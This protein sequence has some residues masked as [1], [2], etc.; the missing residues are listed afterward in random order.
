[1]RIGKGIN[2]AVFTAPIIR[3]WP[4]FVCFFVM[5]GFTTLKSMIANIVNPQYFAGLITWQLPLA[6]CVTYLATCIVHFFRKTWVKVVMYAIGVALFMLYMFLWR[7]FGLYIQP[8][9]VTLLVETN[10]REAS[11][12]LHTF[13][14]S[15]GG[16]TAI[17]ASVVMVALIVG[18]E[19]CREAVSARFVHVKWRNY[20]L[21][22]LL[23]LIA[24]GAYQ[25]KTYGRLATMRTVE[26]APLTGD[27][28]SFDAVTSVA[29]SVLSIPVAQREYDEALL[30][31]TNIAE[32]PLVEDADSL[33]VIF[34]IGESYIKR[35]AGVYGY[36]LNTTPNIAA[37]QRQGRMF[38]FTDV[39]SPIGST[40]QSMKNMLST[41]SLNSGEKWSK[42]PM[43][44]ALFKKAGFNVYFWDNQKCDNTPLYGLSINN[45][46]YGE[47]MLRA[48]YTQINT[49]TYNY[50]GEL[51]DDFVRRKKPDGQ[52]NLVLFHIWGQHI[53]AKARY[54]HTEEFERF[55]YKDIRSNALYMTDAKRQEVAEYDNAT[56]YND[57]VIGKI[58]ET[59]R[60]KNA[61]LVYL[62]DHGEEV[63]DYRDSKGR[64]EVDDDKVSQYLQFINEIPFMI[65]CSD[66]YKALH[67]QI[68]ED[69][70]KAVDRPF[71]I[72]QVPQ[73]LMHL[74]SVKSVYYNAEQDVLSPKF[75]RHRRVLLSGYDYD[76]Q[77]N[78]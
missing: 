36:Y 58:I 16:I 57:Y 7:V 44:T 23:A 64:K 12:F 24:V 76:K 19:K 20:V 53:D 3:Q 54:P 61:V 42:F 35:H 2:W 60:E 40:V 11:E 50:D 13:L 72:D 56:L 21:V 5:I 39:L 68:V 27:T 43:F 70:T 52:H 62:S 25:T 1:M 10:Q 32:K 6:L 17:A 45:L 74:A 22:P 29:Y 38:L 73:V 71:M 66:R 63:Y 46:L 34:V 78:R 77:M 67:P 8:M 47:E 14:L 31:N 75:K 48:C 9:V 26:D 30:T 37:E 15:P 59:Y 49:D 55:S 18:L 28:F 33:N 4:F 69:I 41:N 51:V 65:W